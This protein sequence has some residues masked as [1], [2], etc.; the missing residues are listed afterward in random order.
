MRTGFADISAA[1][2]RGWLDGGRQ[3]GTHQAGR[4]RSLDRAAD[5]G[6]RWPGRTGGDLVSLLTLAVHAKVPPAV[7]RRMHFAFPT[8]HG[9]VMTAL[10]DLGL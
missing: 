8:Y 4:G 5:R 6:R 10:D 7:V 1:S 2:A 3:R 9:A